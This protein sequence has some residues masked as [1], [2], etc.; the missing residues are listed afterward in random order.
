VLEIAF[1]YE[2][3]LIRSERF[4]MI[5]TLWGGSSVHEWDPLS[6]QAVESGKYGLRLRIDGKARS[7]GLSMTIEER[8]WLRKELQEILVEVRSAR[9]NRLDDRGAGS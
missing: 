4:R 7:L 1:G 9:T 2:T 8:D 3:L 6:V 5:R